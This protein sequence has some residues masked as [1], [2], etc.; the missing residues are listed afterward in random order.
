MGAIQDLF[1]E[2]GVGTTLQ[3]AA[4]GALT[5]FFETVLTWAARAVRA[6]QIGFLETQIAGLKLYIALAPLITIFTLIFTNSLVLRGLKTILA[7]IAIA[8]GAVVAGFALMGVAMG[9][10]GAMFGF[11]SGLIQAAILAIVGAIEGVVETLITGGTKGASGFI[12]GLVQGIKG[13][14]GQ[15]AQAVRDLAKNAEAAFTEFF[16]IKSPSTKMKAHARQLPAG[17]AEGIR[18]GAPE[19][20]E[21]MDDLWSPPPT[22]AGGGARG[23]A[24]GRVSV[25]VDKIIFQGR[26]DEFDDFRAKVEKYWDQQEAAGPEPEPA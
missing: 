19:V 26:A 1:A 17:E 24:K 16:G 5:S 8:I 18:D 7:I 22:R 4:K 6:I 25:Y 20:R 23:G 3:D 13:G 11:V 15:V 21:A 9:I 12:D 14:A 10:I 2:F